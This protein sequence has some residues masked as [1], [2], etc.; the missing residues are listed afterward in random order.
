M[1][2]M[3]FLTYG[4]K[5][6]QFLNLDYK[7]NNSKQ[8]SDFDYVPISN[9]ITSQ[10]V[11][12]S[13][14]FLGASQE[15]NV[16]YLTSYEGVTVWKFDAINNEMVKSFYRDVLNVQDISGYS[17]K[18][19][20]YL[21]NID[22]IAV[23][24]SDTDGN[25][26]TVFGIKVD[27]GLVYA[28]ILDSVGNPKPS[29]NMVKVS[30][31]TNVLWENSSGQLIA[32]IF[33]DYNTYSAKA[34]LISFSSNGV[35]GWTTTFKNIAVDSN[36]AKNMVDNKV[37]HHSDTIN[38]QSITYNPA[39]WTVDNG[40]R[41]KLQAVIE[42]ATNS[43]TNIAV[44]TDSLPFCNAQSGSSSTT[45]LYLQQA[46]LVDDNLNPIRNNNQTIVYTL[47]KFIAYNTS[48]AYGV[49]TGPEKLQRYGYIGKSSG[50]DQ[51]FIWL[52]S[53][54][55][56]AV[57]ELTY[58]STTKTLSSSNVYDL[59]WQSD[60]DVYTYSYDVNENCLFTS[61][62][63]TTSNSGIGYIDFN[64][65]NLSYQKLVN[66]VKIDG[67]HNISLDNV[68]DFSPVV[69]E[70]P[71]SGTPIIYFNANNPSKI[72][73]LYFQ[74]NN[75]TIQNLTR[76]AYNDIQQKAKTLSWYSDKNPTSVTKE[77]VLNALVYDSKPSNGDFTNEVVD[78]KGNDEYGTLYVEYKTTYKNWWNSSTT[79]SFYVETT[80]TGMHA[81]NSSL[82]NFSVFKPDIMIYSAS[83]FAA[84]LLIAIVLIVSKTIKT[85]KIKNMNEI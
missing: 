67:Y 54:T 21:K 18:C 63:H 7:N 45:P 71:A 43:N 6:N 19:W 30:D 11:S 35:N 27:T 44:F 53:G 72:D 26:A 65:K 23:V 1:I 15:N 80:I 10:P 2:S 69:C 25:N 38:G 22:V 31:G 50:V 37:S 78:L 55:W 59:Q 8:A 83:I 36:D 9:N 84:F 75:P 16:L 42:G 32:T 56:N 39:N 60:E 5:N 47:S 68:L 3:P 34:F 64:S 4:T 79:S 17:I 48:A 20:K 58:N 85:K 62:T 70:S 41:W 51:K 52:T 14:G 73:G 24:L 40:S 82:S 46:V 29:S 13:V 49:W 81:T 12:T 33:G 61:N 66:P 28:P 57:T 77:E 74:N 76:K